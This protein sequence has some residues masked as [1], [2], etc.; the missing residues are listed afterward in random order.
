MKNAAFYGL[1]VLLAGAA[2]QS[3]AQ[4]TPTK[5]ELEELMKDE[6]DKIVGG[7][8][9]GQK[10]LNEPYVYVEQMPA[11]NGKSDIPAISAFV[12]K[13]TKYPLAARQKN[14]EG[15]VLA[16]FIV[17]PNGAITDPKI[18]RG[19]GNG[20]DEAVL[21]A[22]RH[23]PLFRP[24]RQYGKAVR[25]AL[26]I[27]VDFVLDPVH[28][29]LNLKTYGLSGRLVYTTQGKMIVFNNYEAGEPPK[30]IQARGINF[31]LNFG[32]AHVSEGDRPGTFAINSKMVQLTVAQ[33]EPHSD[34]SAAGL[35]A[36]YIK[37]QGQRIT[38]SFSGLTPAVETVLLENGQPARLWTYTI[39]APESRELSFVSF[40][41]ENHVFMLQAVRVSG[42]QR[43]RELLL[44]TAALI[45]FSAQPIPIEPLER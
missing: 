9:T 30:M 11:L 13:Q 34:T 25:V 31:Y 2:G 20:C 33:L 43:I 14:I 15:Q 44:E 21:E 36:S 16:F 26:T 37:P 8:P 3:C 32:Q 1:L 4:S 24:G 28:H 42:Q 29:P 45:K 40:V 27:P 38:N 5:E 41:H 7:I 6:S 17:E 35:L 19:I 12:Q 18:L 23:L 10:R 22:L 39:P